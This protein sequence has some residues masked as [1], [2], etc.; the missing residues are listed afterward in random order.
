MRREVLHSCY[1]KR[2]QPVLLTDK[3]N[4]NVAA[5]NDPNPKCEAPKAIA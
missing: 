4:Q 5:N 2:Y 3:E 1:N